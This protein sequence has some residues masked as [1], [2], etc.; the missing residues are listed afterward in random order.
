MLIDKALLER[1]LRDVQING[2]LHVGA[3]DCEELSFYRDH[4]G[5]HPDGVYWID[6][7]QFKVDEA[8]ARGVPN[9]Y[10]AVVTDKDEEPVTF[11][12]SNNIQ[13]SSV[14]E[15]KRHVIEHPQV[16]YTTEFEATSITLDTFFKKHDIDPSRL[17]LWN[18][19]I[20]GAELMALTGAVGSLKY[21]DALYLEVNEDELYDGCA[22][23][24][25][26]DTFLVKQGFE[27]VL[28]E[29]TQHGW[30]DAVYKRIR[31]Q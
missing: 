2:V 17:N 12:V 24:G 29:M 26:L 22:L 4:L 9:V 3:H 8:K 28:T 27:R 25:D 20:Q 5:V 21:A 31:G 7:I 14:L 15:L 18:L 23:I 19:D 1:T 11:H 13:S 16:V 30:G 10:Q 6:A